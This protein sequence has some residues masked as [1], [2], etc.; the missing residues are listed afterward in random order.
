VLYSFKFGDDGALPMAG[1]AVDATGKPIRDGDRR[2]YSVGGTIFRLRP[3]GNT[4][5]FTVLH[6]FTRNPD[7]SW[8]ASSLIFDAAGNL[9]GTT[10]E[11]GTGQLCGNYG[12]GTVLEASP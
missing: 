12:C 8:P 6:S 1:V 5:S 9:Y 11:S 10:K 4:W 3:T 7:G 2:R